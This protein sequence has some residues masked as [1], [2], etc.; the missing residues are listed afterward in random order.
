MNRLCVA[1]V[2]LSLLL[3]GGCMAGHWKFSSIEPSETKGRFSLAEVTLD[4]DGT[5]KA[6]AEEGGKR[7]ESTGSWRHEGGKLIFNPEKGEQRIYDAE[8]GDLGGTL[9]ISGT[10]QG[11]KWVAKMKKD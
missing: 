10:E 11:R 6:V 2:G 3:L 1:A 5:Y 8:L 4:K 7:L 9:Y